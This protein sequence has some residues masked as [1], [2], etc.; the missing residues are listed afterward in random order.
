MSNKN[1]VE[2]I[3]KVINSII[4]KY[5]MVPVSDH[6]QPIDEYVFSQGDVIVVVHQ[7]IS[8]FMIKKDYVLF[9]VYGIPYLKNLLIKGMNLLM[10]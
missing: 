10:N 2:D 7:H 3:S 9:H 8:F 5:L 6:L 1:S 4:S